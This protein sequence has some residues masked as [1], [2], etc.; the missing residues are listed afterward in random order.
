MEGTGEK[1]EGRRRLRRGFLWGALGAVAL[2]AIVA[3]RPI[4]AAVQGG[5]RHGLGGRWGHHRLSP[6]AMHEHIQVGVKWALRG[7]DATED[8]QKRVRDIVAGAVDDLHRLKDQ[9]Q[10]NREAFVAQLAGA[11]VNREELEAVRKAEM[12][13]ADDASRRLVQAL[14]DVAEVLTPEQ[15]QGLLEHAR[16][17][18]H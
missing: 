7:V 10:R 9:H 18:H 15:R 3:A 14:A 16:R 2:A 6:E 13:L 4:A 1:A 5:A 8:Q 17:L 12:A 11:D